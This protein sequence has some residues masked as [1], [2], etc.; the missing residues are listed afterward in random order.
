MT[1]ALDGDRERA[2]TISARLSDLHK[3]LFL[4]SN[5]IPVKWALTRMGMIR[6]N[7]RLPLTTLSDVYHQDLYAA[8]RKAGIQV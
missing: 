1:A 2:E 7:I 8:M 6:R 4:E 3:A 5:P